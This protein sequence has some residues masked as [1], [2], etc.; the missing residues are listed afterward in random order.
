MT[1]APKKKKESKAQ[2]PLK[3]RILTA[4]GWNRKMAAE[5]GKRLKVKTLVAPPMKSSKKKDKD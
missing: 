2:K 5:H 1:G 4:E 3:E